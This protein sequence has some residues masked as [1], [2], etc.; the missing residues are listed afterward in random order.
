M[1]FL[2]VKRPHIRMCCEK[3]PFELQVVDG[4]GSV[5]ECVHATHSQLRDTVNVYRPAQPAAFLAFSTHR[6]S[7]PL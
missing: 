4:L 6:L 2:G 1:C 7:D 3:W 5:T